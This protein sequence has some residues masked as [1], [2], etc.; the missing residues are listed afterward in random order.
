MK[1]KTYFQWWLP[2]VFFLL[3]LLDSQLSYVVRILVG[4][5][6]ILNFHLLLMAIIAASFHCKRSYL[7]VVT[8]FIGFLYDNYY[9][10]VL[11]IQMLALP[12]IVLLV[13]WIFSKVEPSFLSLIVSLVIFVTI[14]EFTVFIV[15]IVFK[16]IHATMLNFIVDV[17]GPSL[18]LNVIVF[19]LL[20]YPLKKIIFSSF[21]SKN[22]VRYS[23]S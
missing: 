8:T 15:Q 12:L 19:I 10:G 17:L 23:R 21:Q 11:G 4:G 1:Q 3:M 7:L 22:V 13:Y 2:I 20:Y 18:L 9:Y 5:Q 14:M 16:L 6:V